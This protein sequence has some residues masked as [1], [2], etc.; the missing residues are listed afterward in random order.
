MEIIR[1]EHMGFC[2]GVR[3]AVD[4]VHRYVD[5]NKGQIYVLGMLVHNEFVIEKLLK[6][7]VIF[8]SEEEVLNEETP[9]KKGDIVIIRAHGTTQSVQKKLLE[10]G[11]KLID[12]ACIYVKSA[13]DQVVI[14]E[15]RGYKS[16]FIGDKDHPEVKGITSYGMKPLIFSSLEELVKADLDIN[17]QWVFLFQTTYNKFI[18]Q[19]INEYIVNRFINYKVVKTICG[20][21]HQRQTAIE[22][23][24]KQVDAVFIIGSEQSSNTKKLYQI[25]KKLNEKSYLIKNKED[26]EKYMLEGVKTVGVSAGASTPEDLIAIIE[27]KIKE[28]ID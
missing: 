18:F 28:L 21:T 14:W 1:A 24:S 23:L 15:Q 22:K 7:G 19:E 11:V 27:N 3:E 10:I 5:M 26:I 16:V 9:L 25:S 8:V 20:A 12:M 4:E 17:E 2:F 13:R 6:K